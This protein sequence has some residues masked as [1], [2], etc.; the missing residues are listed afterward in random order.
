M[1][2]SNGKFFRLSHAACYDKVGWMKLDAV[3]F[4]DGNC[5]LHL[6]FEECG[7]DDGDCLV[8]NIIH[9]RNITQSTKYENCTV[10][11]KTYIGE[12]GTELNTFAR[13]GYIR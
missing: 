1:N 7:F 2:Q 3:K 12:F 8:E 13:N 10:A 5:N 4:G 6:N 11:W 9:E